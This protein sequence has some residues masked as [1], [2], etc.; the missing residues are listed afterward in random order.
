MR[1]IEDT[2]EPREYRRCYFLGF[3]EEELEVADFDH[4]DVDDE[5]E[6]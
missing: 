5:E 6:E 4:D 3:T 2:R 1:M